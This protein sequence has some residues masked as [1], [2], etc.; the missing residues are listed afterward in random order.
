[1]SN[2]RAFLKNSILTLGATA[3]GSSLLQAEHL[4]HNAAPKIKINQD[5]V[6]LFQGDS[7]TDNG[8]N[9]ENRDANNTDALGKGYA[10]IAASCLLN[11]Y[12]DKNIKVYNRGISGHRV[13]DLQN[14]WQ[15]DTLDLKP[16]I[17]SI[18]IGVNDF[19]RTMDS[20]A[21]NT[22][23]A[24][25]KQYQ[26]LLDLSL[27]NLPNV[28]LIIGE[29]FGVKNVKH[30]TDKWF[31]AFPEYQQATQEIAKEYNAIL[32]PY[33]SIFDQAEKRAAGSYWTT[34]GVHTSVAG[35]NLMAEHWLKLVK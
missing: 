9:R 31:P 25:K 14:R 30:V 35:A 4:D 29:P 32:L 16:N 8:R 23:Q 15:K 12:A 5:D 20:N 22:P 1:M 3:I 7:I 26:E 24:F 2:R 19:W 33:Q 27:K 34:D 18:L 11:K 17:L 6:I 10:M 13:P 21:K 28:K